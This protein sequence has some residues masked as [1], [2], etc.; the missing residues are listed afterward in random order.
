MYFNQFPIIFWII[1]G[2]YI[3]YR[4]LGKMKEAPRRKWGF[5]LIAEIPLSLYFIWAV[6]SGYSS[7]VNMTKFMWESSQGSAT[8]VQSWFQ[9]QR[10]LGRSQ[11]QSEPPFPFVPVSSFD[12]DIFWGPAASEDH[13]ALNGIFTFHHSQVLW[14][15]FHTN[16]THRRVGLSHFVI[17]GSLSFPCWVF[18]CSEYGINGY[19]TSHQRKWVA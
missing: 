1:K 6:V 12:T 14:L 9:P 18:G 2:L 17:R 15:I 7:V 13:H 10:W 3:H 11:K 4:N 19:S 8:P 5:L 16:E